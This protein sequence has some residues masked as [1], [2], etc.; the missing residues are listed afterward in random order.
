MTSEVYTH[1]LS[2]PPRVQSTFNVKKQG[3]KQF[4]FRDS[5]HQTEETLGY[6]LHDQTASTTLFIV[7]YHV[8]I[9]HSLLYSTIREG[10]PNLRISQRH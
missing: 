10:T 6:Y 9:Y 5:G 7:Q 2:Y 3:N 1:L 8:T 4:I